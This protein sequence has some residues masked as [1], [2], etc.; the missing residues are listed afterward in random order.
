MKLYT[1]RRIISR[2]REKYPNAPLLIG[3]WDFCMYWNTREVQELV[4][5]LDPAPHHDL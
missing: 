3:S 5:E 1:Y 4:A 2:L